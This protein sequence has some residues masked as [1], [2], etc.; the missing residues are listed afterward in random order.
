MMRSASSAPRALISISGRHCWGL[1]PHVPSQ[2]CF[3]PCETPWAVVPLDSPL[4]GCAPA[5]VSDS[6]VGY[7]VWFM[8]PLHW[9][10]AT[11]EGK[12]LRACW[13]HLSLPWWKFALITT[14]RKMGL[15]L[16]VLMWPIP[17]ILQ[18]SVF[19]ADSISLYGEPQSNLKQ[20]WFSFRLEVFF[21]SVKVKHNMQAP[22]KLLLI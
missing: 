2:L 1:V 3:P 22:Q 12:P 13:S 21:F 17:M 5:V 6:A 11:A 4:I 14:A 20:P 7:Q 15:C 16:Q 10:D 9:S 18:G 8:C 19:W